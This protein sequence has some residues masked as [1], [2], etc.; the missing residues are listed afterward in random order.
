MNVKDTVQMPKNGKW[1]VFL[2]YMIV[3]VVLAYLLS[4]RDKET[5]VERLGCYG[6]DAELR[7][8]DSGEG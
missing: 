4:K 8:N 7:F 5:D 3:L 1:A 6:Y 2:F